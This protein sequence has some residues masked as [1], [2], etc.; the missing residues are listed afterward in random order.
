MLYAVLREELPVLVTLDD[1]L[2]ISR[3]VADAVRLLNA[4][5]RWGV[6]AGDSETN[7][8]AV[9]KRYLLLHETFT[10]RASSYDCSA[11]VVLYCTGKNLRCRS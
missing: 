7:H 3:A 9:V 1:V 4:T 6:V 11:V 10:E 2:F 5:T 8:R